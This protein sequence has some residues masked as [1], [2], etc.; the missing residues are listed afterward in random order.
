MDQGQVEADEYTSD[1]DYT[2]IQHTV[3]HPGSLKPP[4]RKMSAYACYSRKV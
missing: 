4:K 2:Q 3:S 1:V